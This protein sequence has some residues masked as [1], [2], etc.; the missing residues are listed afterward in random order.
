[1]STHKPNIVKEQ[2]MV[3]EW[4]IENWKWTILIIF[5]SPFFIFHWFEVC[6]EYA[7]TKCCQRAAY[8]VGMEN[9]KLKM[10]N[11]N[12]FPFSIFH[13][14]LIRGLWW[15]RK[16]QVLSK[17]GVW[18]GNWEWKIENWKWTIIIIF[19]SP[20]FI[21]HWFEGCDEYA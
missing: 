8:G 5:H 4:K 20:F 1:M 15:V 21:F 16:N 11:F 17:S 6:D 19:N 10:N 2:H 14:S 13:F 18:C 3:W 12:N 9:W 7:R